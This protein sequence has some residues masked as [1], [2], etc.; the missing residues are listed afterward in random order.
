MY[1]R[2]SVLKK[3]KRKKKEE[4]VKF[5]GKHALASFLSKVTRNFLWSCF[6][7][8]VPKYDF[9][10]FQKFKNQDILM[11]NKNWGV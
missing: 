8:I 7:L 4:N 6:Y 9:T 2:T 1:N 3:K 5:T 10:K 11:K